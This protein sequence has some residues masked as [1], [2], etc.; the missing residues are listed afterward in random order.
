MALA[1]S[2]TI[3]RLSGK[4]TT[5]DPSKDDEEEEAGKERVELIDGEADV[6][7][8]CSSS[9]CIH[10]HTCWTQRISTGWKVWEV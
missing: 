7:Q 8:L 4:L 6:D 10:W 9:S 2:E 5:G 3:G 1:A